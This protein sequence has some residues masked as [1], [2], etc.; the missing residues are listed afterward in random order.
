M[1]EENKPAE[2]N[3]SATFPAPDPK[4]HFFWGTGRRK[5]AVARVRLRAGDGKFEVNKKPN[6]V[7]FSPYMRAEIVCAMLNF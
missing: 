5:S 7:V 2:T 3:E 4:L 1:S 6:R